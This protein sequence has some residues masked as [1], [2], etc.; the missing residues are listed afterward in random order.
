MSAIQGNIHRIAAI[1]VRMEAGL[2]A[3]LGSYLLVRTL[4]S[5]VEELDAVIAEIVFLFVGAVGLYFAGRGFLEKKNY[6]RGST[7]L[8]NLIALGV[9]YYMIDGDRLLMGLALGLFAVTTILAALT[10]I[11]NSGKNSGKYHQG[12]TS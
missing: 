7:V 9:A 8:A 2:L 11:P 4:T 5:D 6:G 10:A 3:L 1:L 12:T